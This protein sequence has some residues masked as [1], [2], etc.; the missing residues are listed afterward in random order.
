MVDNKAI[1]NNCRV[2]TFGVGSGVDTQL[3]KEVAIAGYGSSFI[4]D[5]PS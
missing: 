1:E 4:V 2:H 3:V 5:Q